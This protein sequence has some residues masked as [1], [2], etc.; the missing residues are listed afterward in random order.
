MLAMLVL[1]MKAL[2]SVHNRL[3]SAMK[4][5]HCWA[6]KSTITFQTIQPCAICKL[7]HY[8]TKIVLRLHQQLFI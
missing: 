2:R 1:G 8:C 4:A 3:D 7:D 5:V 6:V